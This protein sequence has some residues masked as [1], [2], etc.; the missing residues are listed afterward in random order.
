MKVKEN[1]K[2]GRKL[3]SLA[4]VRKGCSGYYYC[5]ISFNKA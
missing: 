4:G 2:N 3:R 1:D 5:T